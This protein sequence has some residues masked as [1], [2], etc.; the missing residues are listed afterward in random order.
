[1]SP[2]PLLV[3]GRVPL[4]QKQCETFATL[5]HLCCSQFGMPK[6]GQALERLVLDRSLVLPAERRLPKCTTY[7]PPLPST[8][9]PFF[10]HLAPTS[11]RLLARV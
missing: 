4:S 6:A 5:A 3:L 2:E 8:E 7:R 1:M 9:N 10:P 11:R